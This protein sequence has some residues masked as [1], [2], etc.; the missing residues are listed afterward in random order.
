MQPQHPQIKSSLESFKGIST[1]LFGVL[2][3]DLF[4]LKHM[5]FLPSSKT[6]LFR[7]TTSPEGVKSG[8]A[9]VTVGQVKEKLYSVGS[10]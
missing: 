6:M 7:T 4:F 1:E 2:R 9:A 10:K 5:G 8:E 3:F